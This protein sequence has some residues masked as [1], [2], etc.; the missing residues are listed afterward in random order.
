MAIVDAD[1]EFALMLSEKPA[2]LDEEPGQAGIN[3]CRYY[4]A[5]ILLCKMKTYRF[6][7]QFDRR[8]K[9]LTNSHHEDFSSLTLLEMTFFKALVTR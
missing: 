7:K 9:S 1:F 2:Y 3:T 6:P 8:E 5:R 4:K